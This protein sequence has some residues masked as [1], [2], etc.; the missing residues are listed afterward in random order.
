MFRV[1]AGVHLVTGAARPTFDRLVDVAEVKVL[2][3]VAKIGQGSRK[4]V[5]GQRL[6]VTAKAQTIFVLGKGGIK[7]SRIRAFEQT[8]IVRPMRVMA[9][10]AI[11]LADRPMPVTVLIQ[12]F[13]HVHDLSRGSFQF[14]VVTGKTEVRGCRP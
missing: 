5:Q 14:F 2:I 10:R 9:S 6:L 4:P 1:V 8:E 12:P 13:F 3:P 11:L 7:I